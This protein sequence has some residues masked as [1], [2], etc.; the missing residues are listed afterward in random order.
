MRR[1]SLILFLLFASHYSNAQVYFNQ[2]RPSAIEWQVLLTD[3][4]K[5]IYPSG[6]DSLAYRAGQILEQ[7]YPIAQKLIGGEL[8]NF[9][10]ILN[11]Y[12]DLSNGFVTPFN[13]RSEIETPPIKGKGLNP[14]TGDWYET[15]LSHELIHALHFSK[16]GGLIADGIGLFWKDAAR[17]TH[18]W[19]PVG[20]H[21]GVAVYHESQSI[22]SYGDGGR[23]NYPFFNNRFLSN[24]DSNQRWINGQILLTSDFTVPYNR[25]YVAGAPFVHWLQETY[26]EDVTRKSIEQHYRTFFLGYGFALRRS[27][28]KWPKQLIRDFHKD[29]ANQRRE[30]PRSNTDTKSVIVDLPFD[31][32]N[33]SRPVW[34]D[35]NKLLFIGNYYDAVSGFYSFD[36]IKQKARL[37]VEAFNVRDFNYDLRGNN[38]LYAAFQGHQILDN[39]FL[40]ELLEADLKTG[41]KRLIQKSERSFAPIYSNDQIISLSTLN[42]DN[43]IQVLDGSGDVVKHIHIEDTRIVELKQKPNGDDLAII[44][45]RKGVQGVWFT[46]S[47]MMEIHLKE[48][49]DISFLNA[50]IF[51]IQWHPVD[52]KI[53]FT[54]DLNGVMNIY[55]YDFDS[56][57]VHRLTDS[58]YNAMEASW[59][60]DQLQLAYAIQYGD[61]KRLAVIAKDDL[62]FEEVSKDEWNRRPSV[63]DRL[64]SSLLGA[65]IDTTSWAKYSYSSKLDWLRP[66]GFVPVFESVSGTDND[67]R[68]GAGVFGADALS[69]HSYY[70][71]LTFYDQLSW[72]D[73]YYRNTSFYPGFKLTSSS[74]PNLVRFVVRDPNNPNQG[75]LYRNIQQRMEFKLSIPFQYRFRS[76]TRLTSLLFEPGLSLE[77]IR[78]F[79]QDGLLN[80]NF[81]EVNNIDVFTQM[82]IN[83]MQLRRDLQPRSGLVLFS[84]AQFGLNSNSQFQRLRDLNNNVYTIERIYNRANALFLGG[85]WY[86]SPLKQFNQSLRLNLSMLT[87]T[88]TLVYNSN[89]LV[90]LGFNEDVF[91]RLDNNTLRFSTRYLIPLR[92]PDQGGITVPLYFSSIYLSAFS[93]TLGG[94]SNEEYFTN[95][96][97]I[98]GMGLRFRMKLSNFVFDIGAGITYEPSRSEFNYIVGEF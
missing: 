12:N 89:S 95:P 54:A 32:E 41:K 13:F 97:T 73:F 47:A 5:V 38:L 76:N 60:P 1:F 94:F 36:L 88:Q 9:P 49:P 14:R 33:S 18:A 78:F 63:S 48:A 19:A 50:S 70:Y 34:L 7:Q 67:F 23:L 43:A 96:R 21:E 79:N 56:D 93:H 68:F 72:W 37:E 27:T 80:S 25:H 28:G 81:T 6:D 65:E 2:Y 16:K 15:V 10:I 40:T 64:E 84:Q 4:F 87:Q 61:E 58:Q 85:Y 46:N 51:D 42:A 30:E 74:T 55:E 44:A 91:T 8:H 31:G 82:N 35:Q 22:S 90:P 69:K 71:A 53:L 3:H 98:V 52:Y 24:F 29:Y 92:Y 45:S 11:N 26:G 39:T 66:R 83:V 62:L 75:I 57:K 77:Q 59:S 86:L 17:I 20:L